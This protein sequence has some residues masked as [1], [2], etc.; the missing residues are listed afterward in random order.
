MT[1]TDEMYVIVR[2]DEEQYSIWRSGRPVPAGWEPVGEPA[3]R[4]D[5]LARIGG[6]WTDMRP[7][8]LRAAMSASAEEQRTHSG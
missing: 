8:S 3:S 5:C 7:A 6:L 1:D 2:N 4:D